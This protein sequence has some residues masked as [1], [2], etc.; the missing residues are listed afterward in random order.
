MSLA[1]TYVFSPTT[2]IRSS[3]VNQNFSDVVN[4]LN[5][6]F[7]PGIVFWFNG[8]IGSIP[9]AYYYCDG[10]NSTPNIKKRS[11]RG[12]GDGLNLGDTGGAETI[13]ILHG[14]SVLPHNHKGSDNG[15]DLRAAIGLTGGSND[16]YSYV[17]VTAANP[18]GGATPNG[19][20]RVDTTYEGSFN[21]WNSWT[22]VYGHVSSESLNTENNLSQTQSVM[23]PYIALVPIMIK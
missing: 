1:V 12:V 2:T 19:N 10:N 21:S 16:K 20:H 6:I 7:Q 17:P 22:K 15:G 18:N 9:S 14:H 11:I 23:N 3:E 5:N 13:N 8:A 4:F